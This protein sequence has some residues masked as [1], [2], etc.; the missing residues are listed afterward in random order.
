MNEWTDVNDRLPEKDQYVL[1]YVKNGRP[2]IR[3][4]WYS[5]YVKR[6]SYLGFEGEVIT[7][8]MELPEFPTIDKCP[9][10]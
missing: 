1:T 9:Y 8:W 4:S 10:R 7:H 2:S 3:I 5:T 6:W